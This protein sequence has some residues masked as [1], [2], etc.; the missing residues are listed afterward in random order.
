MRDQRQRDAD[1]RAARSRHPPGEIIYMNEKYLREFAY[2]GSTAYLDA[3]SLGIQP[4]RTL[5]RC[6]DFQQEFIRSRGRI[7]LEHY[8][9]LRAMAR[10]R[11]AVLIH[12]GADEVFFDGNTTTGFQQLCGSLPL[13]PGEK[14]ALTD[15]DYPSVYSGW[16]AAGVPIV[17]LPHPNGCVPEERILEAIQR[18]DVRAVSVSFVQSA[19]GYKLDLARIGHAC[20]ERGVYFCVDGIQGM[21]RNEVDVG[22]D[23]IDILSCG[24]FK[25]LMGVLGTGAHF[26]RRDLLPL[27][28]PASFDSHN[29]DVRFGAEGISASRVHVDQADALAVGSENTYG[30]EALS[31]SLSLLLEIGVPEIERHVRRLERLYREG[32]ASLNLHWLGSPDEA[33]WSGNAVFSYDSAKHDAL[34]RALAE[35]DIVVYVHP[36]KLRAGFHFYNTD[37]HVLRLIRVLKRVFG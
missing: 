33:H 27:M 5:D 3:G 20:R 6:A 32:V 19:S 36:D 12:A 10:S 35:E 7:C 1:S 8:N 37:E 26:V 15:M 14:V 34:A 22:R 31:T 25:A 16:A 21:G 9:D 13:K 11:F 2:L 23:C 18:D 28:R 30:I 17:A 29:L 24:G 4:K